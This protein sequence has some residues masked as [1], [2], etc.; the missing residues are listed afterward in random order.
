MVLLRTFGIDHPPLLQ[1]GA[2]QIDRAGIRGNDIPA[3]A[4]HVEHDFAVV[5]EGLLDVAGCKIVAGGLPEIALLHTDDSE[6]SGVSQHPLQGC[7]IGEKITHA[8]FRFCKIRSSS[9]AT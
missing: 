1:T 3:D 9:L 5:R 7:V 4:T 8:L 6:E 2:L